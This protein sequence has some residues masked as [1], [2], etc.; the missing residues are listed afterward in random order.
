MK[1]LTTIEELQAQ[2][3][4]WKQE[5]DVV[6]LVP[7]MGALHAGHLSLVRAARRRGARGT[8]RR[9][10][11]IVSIFVNPLQF[12]PIEDY[13]RYPRPLGTDLRM[14]ERVGVDV[15]FHPSVD[16]MYPAGFDT[17]VSAGAVAAPLEGVARPGHFDGVATVVARL[18]GAAVADRAYF[19]QKDAQQLAVIRR[20]VQDLAIPVD[21]V[22]CPTVREVDGLA[23]SSRN[24]YLEGADREHALA[25]VGALAEAQ[26]LYREGVHET[27]PLEAA[28]R[29]VLASVP[30][31][32]VEY[33]RIVDPAT[34]E[35]PAAGGEG[36]ALIAARVGPARLIDNAALASVD[37]LSHRRARVATRRRP[38]L[39]K[40]R[41][42]T[43]AWNV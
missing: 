13:G 42:E 25:L 34:F 23:M 24:G 21:I 18:V 32:V 22:G 5:G 28:M 36:L 27:A 6:S 2:S 11:V 26:G 33:A 43:Q 41:K 4:K 15:V 7:T 35:P 37:V 31:V 14:L 40:N 30:G 20:T 1:V 12:G 19:G 9:P 10:R 17:R 29:E 8:E 39:R 38:V 3:R 16:E